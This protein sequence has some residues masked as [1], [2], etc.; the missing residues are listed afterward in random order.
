[1]FTKY[2][3]IQLN[4]TMKKHGIPNTYIL[5]PLNEQELKKLEDFAKRK[6]INKDPNYNEMIN[7]IKNPY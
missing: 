7:K 2:E 5:K 6:N 1:M 4:K 3:S